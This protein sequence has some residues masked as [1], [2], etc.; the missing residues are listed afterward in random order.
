MPT[1]I[2]H[3]L[4]VGEIS[5]DF[6]E[7]LSSIQLA[8]L[9]REITG[10]TYAKTREMKKA[11]AVQLVQAL[12]TRVSAGEKPPLNPAPP[13]TGLGGVSIKRTKKYALQFKGPVRP[14]KAGTKRAILVDVLSRP[15]G[16]TIEECMMA[17][18]NDQQTC[19]S[20]IR[21]LHVFCGYGIREDEDGRIHLVD[22]TERIMT[23]A[24]RVVPEI[25]PEFVDDGKSFFD[26]ERSFF[27]AE[28]PIGPDSDGSMFPRGMQG[29]GQA[30]RGET[31]HASGELSG[32]EDGQG[33]R[34]VGSDRTDNGRAC[35]GRP[36]P[37]AEC[38]PAYPQ[39]P[40][41]TLDLSD[42]VTG[43]Y[44]APPVPK[45]PVT[46]NITPAIAERV[47]LLA[48]AVRAIDAEEVIHKALRY[49]YLAVNAVLDKGEI[50]IRHRDGSMED[51]RPAEAVPSTDPDDFDIDDD[52]LDEDAG[53]EDEVDE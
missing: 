29:G 4:A 8:A 2:Y 19:D 51:F 38:L 50:T 41:A 26:T 12:L 52:D 45:V 6:V 5:I 7:T 39:G 35:H 10:R 15:E 20:N 17:I 24:K 49:Y 44:A 48:E 33:A 1:N 18:G 23:T 36:A 42:V 30:L 25:S 31:G 21:N 46:V 13:R 34:R 47:K 37:G 3:S 28:D 16:A 27:N 9:F 14:P 40:I 11:E 32:R 43:E 53:F 22:R